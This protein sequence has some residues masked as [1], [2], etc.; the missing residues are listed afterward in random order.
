MNLFGISDPKEIFFIGA[1]ESGSEKSVYLVD[2]LDLV[3][4]P[5]DSWSCTVVDGSVVF[6]HW[7]SN[8]RVDK[9]SR[10]STQHCG[11]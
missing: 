9:K 3:S 11:I 7:D 8:Y 2:V 10:R 1:G 6:Q 4:L 5:S